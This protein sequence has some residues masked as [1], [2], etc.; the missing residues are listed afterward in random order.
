MKKKLLVVVILVGLI[1]GIFLC[2][3]ASA[4]LI[5]PDLG[6]ALQVAHP[7]HEI[8]VIITFADNVDPHSLVGMKDTE[9][10]LRRF[11]IVKSLRDKA[12][13]T[14]AT[15]TTML[16]DRGVKNIRQLWIVNAMA[17]VL[18]AQVIQE[19]AEQ[20]E[21]DRISLDQVMPAPSVTPG[22]ATISEWNIDAIRAP[23]LWNSGYTGQGVV[24]AS[25]DTGVDVLHPDLATSWRGG[26]NSWYDPNGEHS[27]PDD[28]NGHGTMTMGIMVG[29]SAGGTNIGVAPNAKWIAAK[30]YD[31]SDLTTYSI[32]HQAFQWL[33]DPDNDPATDDVP[34]VLNISWGIE[35]INNCSSEFQLDINTLK[36]AGVAVAI[37]AGNYGPASSTSISPG[38]YP[39]S[40]AVGATDETLNIASFSSRGPSAC[41]N[42][43]Y[44]EVVAPGVNIKTSDLTFGG[45]FPDSYRYV[46]GTSVSAPHVAGA[47]ALLLSVFPNLT[48]GEMEQAL[49]ESALD[50]GVAGADNSYGQGFVDALAAFTA[51]GGV[52][53]ETVSEPSTPIGPTKAMLGTVYLFSTGG[54]LSSNGDQVQYLFDWGDGTDSG[55][56]PLGTTNASKS[57]ASSGNFAVRARARCTVHTL[58]TSSWSG[59]VSV[60]VSNPVTII[61]SSKGRFDG[62]VLES[63]KG[64]GV[65]GSVG[66]NQVTV[67][68]DGKD[69][70]RKGV[71]S[72]DTSK[73]PVDAEISSAILKLT[74]KN[75]IG[76]NPFSSLG[77]CYVD[78]MK[79][80]FNMKSLQKVDFEASAT[81]SKVAVMSDPVANGMPSIGSLSVEG[82]NAVNKGGITQIRLL[83]STP[84]NNNEL[85]DLII[86]YSGEVFFKA[87]RPTLEVTYL[88]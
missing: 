40:F 77:A 2:P 30:I 64:S 51:L 57:W 10:R 47:M 34:D 46:S 81:A 21:V 25:M 85:T 59:M 29:G 71:L 55:W 50:L 38:N 45:V 79:G 22:I 66:R 12:E 83:F 53:A 43:I 78:V 17:A 23:V 65:G 32:I 62:W 26:T 24:V 13:A 42:T 33:L 87:K 75:V 36:A 48:P 52:P 41:D 15:L 70:Q 69:R 31:D 20:P 76:T 86:F 8:P 35:I 74:V 72:F 9:K 3:I 14:Q 7:R 67:G 68:D 44:P 54:A 56:L 37:A 1:L 80:T 27:A 11:Q 60:K 49:K 88:P 82:I 4:G 63:S 18:P 16:K 73:I 39:G 5:S 19:I 58:V 61:V 84:S 6:S 28:V